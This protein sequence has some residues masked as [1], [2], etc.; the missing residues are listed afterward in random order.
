MS[1]PIEIEGWTVTGARATASTAS[2]TTEVRADAGELVVDLGYH[3]P[4]RTEIPLAVVAALL[5]A[6][7]WTVVEPEIRPLM[8]PHPGPLP[9]SFVMTEPSPTQW[10]REMLAQ[11]TGD[12]R[13]SAVFRIPYERMAA[14]ADALERPPFL[15]PHPVHPVT[16]SVSE[17]D[18]GPARGV[19]DRPAPVGLSEGAAMTDANT[20]AL[21]RRALAAG[22]VWTPGAGSRSVV[23]F[24][25]MLLAMTPTQRRKVYHRA[26]WRP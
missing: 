10:L 13:W 7:G 19:G 1:E 22:F 17:R 12:V 21:G 8:P 5:R 11:R 24:A 14:I 18:G 3:G 20:I 15:W 4:V 6:R 16:M 26:P 23:D 9:A 25:A 2:D